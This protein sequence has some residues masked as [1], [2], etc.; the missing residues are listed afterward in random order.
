VRDWSEQDDETIQRM[1]GLGLSASKIANHL[2]IS[3]N[4]VIGR[5][6]RIRQFKGPIL[7]KVWTEEMKQRHRD[8]YIALAANAILRLLMR[9]GSHTAQ[10]IT[11]LVRNECG[12]GF[13]W[14][15]MMKMEREGLVW[16]A[17]HFD[18][19]RAHR[20]EITGCGRIVQQIPGA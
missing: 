15:A 11:E 16:R 6:R 17:H 19:R 5:M 3:R 1:A 8:V 14:D 12:L 18:W 20:W 13:V 9:G 7:K 4:A 10:E 2:G